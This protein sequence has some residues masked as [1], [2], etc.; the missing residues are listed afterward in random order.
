MGG[1]S[2][3]RWAELKE[4]A[5]EPQLGGSPSW[6]VWAGKERRCGCLA[7][8]AFRTRSCALGS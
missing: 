5:T 2:K 3:K 8:D 7:K 6:G 1:H 4:G